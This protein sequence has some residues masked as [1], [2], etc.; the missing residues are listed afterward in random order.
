MFFWLTNQLPASDSS[1]VQSE[2]VVFYKIS[3]LRTVPITDESYSVLC[4]EGTSSTPTA[5]HCRTPSTFLVS[6]VAEWNAKHS[7]SSSFFFFCFFSVFVY[8][9][10]SLPL[11]LIHDLTH[12]LQYQQTANEWTMLDLLGFLLGDCTSFISYAPTFGLYFL[13]VKYNTI[14]EYYKFKKVFKV[15]F[16]IRYHIYRF[17]D[18]IVS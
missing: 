1:Y 5:G 17:L 12:L 4:S 14:F 2:Q 10:P 11:S 8:F 9:A 7:S 13:V 15:Y 16:C 6:G 3:H 18:A